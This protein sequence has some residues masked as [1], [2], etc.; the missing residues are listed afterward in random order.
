MGAGVRVARDVESSDFMVTWFDGSRFVW[1]LRGLAFAV[2]AAVGFSL[3]AV[4]ATAAP[5]SPE[6]TA[7]LEAGEEP[8]AADEV[9]AQVS[10][11]ASGSRVEVLSARTVSSRTWVNPDGSLTTEEAGVPVR[12]LASDGSWRDIDTTLIADTAGSARAGASPL[13]LSVAGKTRAAGGGSRGASETDLVAVTEPA[14][15]AQDGRVVAAGGEGRSVVVSWPGALPAPTLEGDTATYAEVSPGVDVTVQ[16]RRSGF[17]QLTVLKSKAAVD[18]AVEAGRGVASWDLVVKTK[19]LTARATKAGGVVFVDAK[20]VVVSSV[21][22]MVAWD[23]EVDE[24]SGE[25]VNVAPVK[26]SVAQRGKGRAV[27]TLTPDQ[28]WLTD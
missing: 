6:T 17:E 15:L 19:G 24:A 18:A 13:G 11:R 26:V 1:W 12:F 8:S 25:R 22:P 10:A 14:Q 9:S 27:L 23:G 21:A 3:G 28:E 7:T 16:A 2:A 4:V 20:G 5:A